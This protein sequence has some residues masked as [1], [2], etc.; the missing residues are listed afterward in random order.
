MYSDA[1]REIRRAIDMEPNNERYLELL[2]E[3]QR[4]TG[5]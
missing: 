1:E 4:E 5:R 2:A 3:I